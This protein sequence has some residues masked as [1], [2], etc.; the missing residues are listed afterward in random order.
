MLPEVTLSGCEI[1]SCLD[2]KCCKVYFLGTVNTG[3]VNVCIKLNTQFSHFRPPPPQSAPP[4]LSHSAESGHDPSRFVF[5]TVEMREMGRDGYSDTEPCHPVDGHGRTLSMPR[6]S[7]D[8]QVSTFI[9]PSLYPI[10]P[11]QLAVRTGEVV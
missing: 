5:Q 11:P 1:S 3:T 8:N 2:C 6:L 10:T 9:P 4:M 7:A